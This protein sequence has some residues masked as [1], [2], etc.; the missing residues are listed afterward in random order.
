MQNYETH[1]LKLISVN[2]QGIIFSWFTNSP[3][4]Q[5]K[6]GDLMYDKILNAISNGYLM[7]SKWYMFILDT[8]PKLG[9]HQLLAC[10]YELEEPEENKK[11][12]KIKNFKNTMIS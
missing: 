7:C 11:P 12:F 10:L 1:P 8:N 3:D 4:F 6:S 2:D 9:K 5:L